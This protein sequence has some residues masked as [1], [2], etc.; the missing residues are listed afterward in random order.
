MVVDGGQLTDVIPSYYNNISISKQVSFS[1]R[2]LTI[3]RAHS[4]IINGVSGIGSEVVESMY[5]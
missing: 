5:V 1:E 2:L 4:F 3:A